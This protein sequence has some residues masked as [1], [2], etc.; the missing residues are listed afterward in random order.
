MPPD[1]PGILLLRCS[2]RKLVSIYPRSTPEFG[3]VSFWGQSEPECLEKPF[4]I[5]AWTNTKLNSYTV[6]SLYCDL[7]SNLEL[8][9]SLVRVCY[10]ESLFCWGF[11]SHYQGIPYSGLSSVL[12]RPWEMPHFIRSQGCKEGKKTF[13]KTYVIIGTGLCT[14]VYIFL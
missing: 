3:N 10:T 13:Y 7:Y 2:F 8:V 4:E 14:H 6:N 5:K 1:L 11:H 12:T 9:S